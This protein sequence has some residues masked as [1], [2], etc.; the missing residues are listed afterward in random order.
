[1]RVAVIGAGVSGL[2]AVKCCLDEG[3]DVVCL[4]S[5]NDLGGLWNYTETVQPLRPT[6][7]RL[8]NITL[9]M[10]RVNG[11]SVLELGQVVAF[12]AVLSLQTLRPGTDFERSGENTSN[13]QYNGAVLLNLVKHYFYYLPFPH[14]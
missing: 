14:P 6:V 2:A 10:I 5:R 9:L 7:A 11:V 3:L 13:F 1:M 4:E 8:E 12:V